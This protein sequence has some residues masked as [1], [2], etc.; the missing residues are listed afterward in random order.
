MGERKGEKDKPGKPALHFAPAAWDKGLFVPPAGAGCIG[1]FQSLS[2]GKGPGGSRHKEGRQKPR[3]SDE[4]LVL[5][6][7]QHWEKKV[8]GALGL[9]ILLRKQDRKIGAISSEIP[10]TPSSLR[11]FHPQQKQAVRGDSGVPR[12]ACVREGIQPLPCPRVPGGSLWGTTPHP[13]LPVSA[14]NI[15]HRG[16]GMEGQ[17]AQGFV[18]TNTFEEKALRVFPQQL[19]R[20]AGRLGLCPPL[21][22]LLLLLVKREK[23]EKQKAK[24]SWG[25]SPGNVGTAVASGRGDVAGSRG[26]QPGG[27]RMGTGPWCLPGWRWQPRGLSAASQPQAASVYP[28]SN[29]V[30]AL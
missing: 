1:P 3:D 12:A 8:L 13:Q 25:Q 30:R 27:G 18:K 16:S 2:P 14:P 19:R 15:N 26:L 4:Q 6:P 9:M 20:H 17:M 5:V 21:P 11:P 29:P 10:K 28:G 24:G 23:K 22:P 7:L